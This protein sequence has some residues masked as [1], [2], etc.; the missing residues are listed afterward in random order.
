MGAPLRGHGRAIGRPG[1]PFS[2]LPKGTTMTLQFISERR[3]DD[4]VLEREFTLGEIPGFL[5]TPG[6]ASPSAPGSTPASAS[7]P[8]PLILLGHPGGLAKMYPRLVARARH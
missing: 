8:I 2:A 4:G 5:W 7:A 1:A 6:S 3:L